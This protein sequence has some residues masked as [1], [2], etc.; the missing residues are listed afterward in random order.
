LTDVAVGAGVAVTAGVG[1][2]RVAALAGSR[3]GIV[4]AGI[5]IVAVGGQIAV[6]VA[7]VRI[8]VIVPVVAFLFDTSFR[9]AL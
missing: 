8:A 9:R 5:V 1:V 4:R 3:A 6:I 2:V 7:S